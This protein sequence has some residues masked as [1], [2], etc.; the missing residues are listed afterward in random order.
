M[1]AM[2]M[3]CSSL[4]SRRFFEACGFCVKGLIEDLTRAQICACGR[5]TFP[6]CSPAKPGALI[7]RSKAGIILRPDWIQW[8][9][10][11]V[12]FHA[13]FTPYDQDDIDALMDMKEIIQKENEEKFGKKAESYTKINRHTIVNTI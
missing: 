8:K 4:C 9:R 5:Q 13:D 6:G 3:I 12:I 7:S 1:K 2:I 10:R 11:T